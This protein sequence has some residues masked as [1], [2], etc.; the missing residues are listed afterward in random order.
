MI[1]LDQKDLS[2]TGLD[3]VQTKL[4][5]LI[6]ENPEMKVF[7]FNLPQ[8]K[9]C[10]YTLASTF[11]TMVNNVKKLGKH[12]VFL[13]CPSA[14]LDGFEIIEFLDPPIVSQEDLSRYLKSISDLNNGNNTDEEN[15][16]M[17]PIKNEV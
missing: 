4:N 1:T 11:A 13:E 3:H 10:D 2:F 16:G 7:V 5:E 9:S 6:M 15:A 8:I 12:L 17:L 14:W